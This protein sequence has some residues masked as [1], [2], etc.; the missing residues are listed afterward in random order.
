VKAVFT[1]ATNPILGIATSGTDVYFLHQTASSAFA[2]EKIDAAGTVTTM[3]TTTTATW[4]DIVV[5]GNYLFILQTTTGGTTTYQALRYSLS[6]FSTPSTLTLPTIPRKFA[7]NGGSIVYV[8]GNLTTRG[9]IYFDGNTFATVSTAKTAVV[10]TGLTYRSGYLYGTRGS[11][12][13]GFIDEISVSTLSTT[14]VSPFTATSC[15]TEIVTPNLIEWVAETSSFVIT[16]KNANGSLGGTTNG[17][18]YSYQP[19]FNTPGTL[20][21]FGSG[22]L[23]IR[24]N[25]NSGTGYT[26]TVN[27]T[28]LPSNTLSTDSSAYLYQASAIGYNVTAGGFIN[29]FAGNGTGV[30]TSYLVKFYDSAAGSPIGGL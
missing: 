11:A 24:G 27:T 30:A 22:T 2:V 1:Q 26:E 17:Q 14:T 18:I 5:A 10:Y 4:Q 19:T 25:S 8:N 7:S 21:S 29:L 20:S 12:G 28:M 15:P 9:I 13:G 6:G 23:L 3:A 16:D